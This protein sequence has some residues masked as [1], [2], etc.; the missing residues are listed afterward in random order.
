MKKPATITAGLEQAIPPARTIAG[1]DN[2]A[3]I[4]TSDRVAV[5]LPARPG[6]LSPQWANG[7]ALRVGLPKAGQS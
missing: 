2:V 6:D 7:Y 1:A 4:L 5:L 3:A